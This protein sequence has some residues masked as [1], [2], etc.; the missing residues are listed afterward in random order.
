MVSR[1]QSRNN[2]YS[3]SLFSHNARAENNA[4]S[5]IDGATALKLDE[6]YEVNTE[7]QNN[8]INNFEVS[9]EDQIIENKFPEVDKAKDIHSGISMESASYMESNIDEEENMNSIPSNNDDITEEYTPKLFSE[10]QSY[11]E[12][13]KIDEQGVSSTEELFD[14]DT[15]E[16]EDFEIPAFLRKQKF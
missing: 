5:S 8:S 2:G 11:H 3:D 15:N 1:I 4:L 12:D 9:T 10:E 7:E 13:T 6:N 16:E 14:Q